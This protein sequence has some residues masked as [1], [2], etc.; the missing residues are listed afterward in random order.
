MKFS[1]TLI[2][3]LVPA[4]KSKSD[5]VD[6]LHKYSF[7]T[8]NLE[9][10][11]FNSEIPHNRYSNAASHYGVAGE[12]AAILNSKLNIKENKSINAPEKKGLVDVKI[13]TSLCERY[14]ARVFDI[15]KIDKSPVW[16][17]KILKDCGLKSINAVVDV[18][19]YVMLEVGQPLHAF[20]YEKLE[21]VGKKKTIYVRLARNG[22]SFETID[23]NKFKLDSKTIV[24]SDKKKALAIAG[25]KGGKNS[26]VEKSTKRII[27]EAATF[28]AAS[29]YKTSKTLKLV[30]DASVRFSHGLSR[31]LTEI[32]INRAT[33]LLGEIAKAKLVDSKDVYGKLPGKE[34]IEFNVE[35]FKSLSGLDL[36]KPELVSYLKRLN[37]GI[38]D[39]AKKKENFLVD[40]PI[41]RDDVTIF[42][43][44]VEE[45]VRLYG[46]YRIPAAPPISAIMPAELEDSINVKYKV[47]SFLASAGFSEIYNS[48]FVSIGNSNSYEIANPI[49]E[50]KKFLR[51]D[52]LLHLRES[53][54]KN[55]KFFENLRMFEIGKIF[56][57]KKEELHLG[58]VARYKGN[59]PFLE[60]KGVVDGLLRQ[61]GLTDIFMKPVSNG[62]EI[63]SSNLN[64][65]FI[66]H[67]G[68]NSAGCEIDLVKLTKLIEEE[69]EYKPIPK[70]PAIQRDLS[71]SMERNTS[72]GSV[73]ETIQDSKAKYV[74]NVDLMDYYDEKR[75]TFRI[76][77]QAEDHT[78]TDKEVNR[79]MDKIVAFLKSKYRF[80]VR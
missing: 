19:N 31:L 39:K 57:N 29:I 48:S 7:E 70:Y 69:D 36:T 32:G 47:R 26:E 66:K 12:L 64:I 73:T 77:F 18:M 65:G 14:T 67:L 59:E 2:K 3:K 28:N 1:Y 16:M 37:F 80:E 40:V 41:L 52:L 58:I 72:V 33:E 53:L 23:K 5:L 55:S 56:V 42:E 20:D 71:L 68:S 79:E 34:I 51:T 43:D 9:G 45:V 38:I 54:G 62:L 75:F 63:E 15:P 76:I 8:D 27:V 13:E 25:I 60:I 24:I 74:Y 50:D 78:L 11:T 44:L 61:S 10:D 46:L 17:Q 4:V 30:T 6:K 35:K 21:G 22:E 49:S